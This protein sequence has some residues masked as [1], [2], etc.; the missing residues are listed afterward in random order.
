M[1][2]IH[3]IFFLSLVLFFTESCSKKKTED[4]KFDCTLEN[5]SYNSDIKPIIN[6]RCSIN[7]CHN[8][9]SPN[10]D[11]TTYLGVK[12]KV[13]NGSLRERVVT[14]KDMPSGSPL[15]AEDIAKFECWITSGSKE[16]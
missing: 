2:C 14:K 9:G 16:N 13:D 5:Y 15:S 1:K 12:T 3:F 7:G 8:S 10:G 4:T 11:Y 6:S